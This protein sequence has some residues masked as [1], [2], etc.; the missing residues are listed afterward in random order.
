MYSPTDERSNKMAKRSN[1]EVIG[2]TLAGFAAV[3]YDA[4]DRVNS[5]A[6]H[7]IP[8]VVETRQ[9][10]VLSTTAGVKKSDLARVV[11]LDC[12]KDYHINPASVPARKDIIARLMKE[13][14]LTQNGA[15]TYLQNMKT[16]AGLVV[17]K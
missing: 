17:K 4:E 10:I 16:K 13:C 6:E 11:F 15:A 5:D 9:P 1:K 2:A 14:G 3:D 12:Y 7:I 8:A